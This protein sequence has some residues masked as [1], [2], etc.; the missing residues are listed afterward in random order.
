MPAQMAQVDVA[1]L[2]D[3][4]GI[5]TVTAKEIRSGTEAKVTVTPAHGLT[6]D[7]VD[8]IVLESV[9]HA[10][11]DF[12]ERRTIELIEKGKGLASHTRKVLE[13]PEHEVL[14][15]E[16]TAI[17]SALSHLEQAISSRDGNRIQSSLDHL[18]K[19]TNPLAERMMNKTVQAALKDRKL[20]DVTMGV[21]K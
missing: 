19:V 7:E 10:R 9:E 16:R 6:K 13:N 18:S 21:Q 17:G 20:D 15:E 11:E 5:L 14:P 3:A 2:V 12:H 8:R 1:F 4:N